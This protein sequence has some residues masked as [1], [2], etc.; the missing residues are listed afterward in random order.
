MQKTNPKTF[1]LLILALF[2]VIGLSGCGQKP[3]A[4]TNIAPQKNINQAV[5]NN[6]NTTNGEE[7]DISDWN[8]YKNEKYGFE[9]KYPK[10]YEI[11]R[12]EELEDDDGK[13]MSLSVVNDNMVVAHISLYSEDYYPENSEG[14]CTYYSG[15]PIDTSIS[16]SEAEKEFADFQ[17]INLRKVDINGLKGFRFFSVFSYINYSLKEMVVAPLENSAFSNVVI[18]SSGL[19]GSEY[20]DEKPDQA[21]KIKDDFIAD[22]KTKI[23]SNAFNDIVDYRTYNNIVNSFNL[24]KNK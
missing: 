15:K 22:A 6:T 16:I 1:L 24:I 12:F 19:M 23:S 7:I 20:F 2:L 4:N 11:K 9:F 18:S 5:N 10:S 8:T 13:K 17:P 3:V 14:C 21:Q